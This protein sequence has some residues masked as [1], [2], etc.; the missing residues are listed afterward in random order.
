MSIDRLPKEIRDALRKLEPKLRR[1]FLDAIGD[2]RK[3]VDPSAIARLIEAGDIEAAIK[4]MRFEPSLFGPIDRTLEEAYRDAGIAA[5]AAL[6]VIRDPNLGGRFVIGFDGRHP[7]AELWARQMSSR[8][9][10]EIVDD[11]RNMARE[12]IQAGVTAGRSPLTT[13]LDIVGRINKATG[14]REGGFIGL[15]TGQARW[16]SAA[17][18]Q[19]EAGQFAEFRGRNL[20]N[21]SLD[22]LIRKA[23]KEGRKLTKREIDQILR[24]YTN[25]I[26]RYRG[27]TI[28]R[29]ESITALRAGA[30]EGYQQL[31]ESGAVSD[32]QIIRRWRATGDVRTRD[33][34]NHMNDVTLR[35][36]SAPW[37]V[38][39]SLMMYPGDTSLG[40]AAEETIN[41][42][43]F[44]EYR[45]DRG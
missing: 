13:A 1:A 33:S 2:I 35:G 17:R 14:Q 27:E 45:I 21:K 9:I 41:C 4:A 34:H 44:V 7:R 30:M 40:A 24:G 3:A 26:L 28:A 6:P 18:D 43:C 32:N 5:L 29:T 39:T 38:G 19:L 8:L 37:V 12:Q 23:E 36:L 15:T 11:Q 16:V 31:V 22:R 10:T 25:N 20:R 42:R